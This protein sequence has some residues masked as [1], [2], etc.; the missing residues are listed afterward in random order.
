MS[1]N[2]NENEFSLD[3]L[4]NLKNDLLDTIQYVNKEIKRIKKDT[5]PDRTDTDTDTDSS[6][7]TYTAGSDS[8]DED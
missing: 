2:Q 1:E 7:D 8:S 4:L 6:D 5:E 3:F